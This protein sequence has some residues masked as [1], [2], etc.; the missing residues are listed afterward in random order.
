MRTVP[1]DISRDALFRPHLAHGFFPVKA[2]L[3]D[4]LLCAEC[5]LLVYKKFESDPA[6]KEEARKALQSVGFED[7]ESFNESG[8]QA[9]AAWSARSRTAVVA[10]RGTEQEDPT[11][12]GTDVNTIPVD[13]KQG[14]KVHAGFKEYWENLAQ[15]TNMLQWIEKHPGR[16]LLTGHSL[17]AALSTLGA[18]HLRPAKLVTIGSPRI[19]NAAFAETLAGIEISRYV[20][21]CDI[22]THIPPPVFGFVHVKPEKPLYIDRLGEI[23]TGATEDFIRGDGLKARAEYLLHDAWRRGS[24]AIRDLADHTPINYVHALR[25]QAAA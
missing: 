20:D 17:G 10:F 2:K 23:K 3:S 4:D 8:S 6:E 19:G 1:Y 15:G 7:V 22:V 13:W 21:C 25:H 9:F 11:D 12:L 14:G 24:V 16:L 18:S 5:A